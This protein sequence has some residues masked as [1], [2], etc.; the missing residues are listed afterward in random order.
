MKLK[1]LGLDD[2]FQMRIKETQPHNYSL[3]RITAIN[4]EKA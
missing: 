4:K 3:A 1:E 2:W